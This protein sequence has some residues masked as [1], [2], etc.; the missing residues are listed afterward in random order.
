V[1]ATA[2]AAVRAASGAAGDVASDVIRPGWELVVRAARDEAT[3]I[4]DATAGFTQTEG[5][6]GL[7]AWR[8]A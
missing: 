2:D 7:L 4:A 8:L 3:A 1:A 5:A 6:E